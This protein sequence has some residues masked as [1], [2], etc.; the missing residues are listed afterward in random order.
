[1]DMG[2]SI[3]AMYYEPGMAFAGIWDNGDDDFYDYSGM[4]SKQIRED[5]PEVLD[6]AFGI[7]ESAEM[8]EEENQEIDL[9]GG[10]SATNEQEQQNENK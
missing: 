5:L 10:L 1:M 7:S 4:D 2:F 3:R 6:D 8:W 9:D